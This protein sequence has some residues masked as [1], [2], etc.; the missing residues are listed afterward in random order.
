MLLKLSLKRD[1][2]DQSQKEALK[3]HAMFH[4]KHWWFVLNW[5]PPDCL[6]KTN[7][8]G[9]WTGIQISAKKNSVSEFRRSQEAATVLLSAPNIKFP[10][11]IICQLHGWMVPCKVCITLALL[12]NYRAAASCFWGRQCDSVYRHL[13]IVYNRLHGS[14]GA[15]APSLCA[16]RHFAPPA[17]SLSAHTKFRGELWRL[18]DSKLNYTQKLE[19]QKI[20]AL[21]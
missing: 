4:F 6:H 14:S 17:P 20:F 12:L 3:H 8:T 19:R 5:T 9:S 13:M 1:I 7:F 11:G 16:R 15:A 10:T 21:D 2:W 18:G